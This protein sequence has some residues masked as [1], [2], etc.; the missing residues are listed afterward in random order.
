M[1]SPNGVGKKKC[2][3]S[4]VSSIINKDKDL[5]IMKNK[6]YIINSEDGNF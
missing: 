5:K 4:F 3:S 6:D 1:S 2:T